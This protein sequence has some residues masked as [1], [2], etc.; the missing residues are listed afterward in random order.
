M[1]VCDISSRYSPHGNGYIK[2]YRKLL[3]SA[4]FQNEKLLKV[5]IWCLIR[6]NWHEATCIFEGKELK[7]ERG[8][9][10]TGRYSGSEECNMAPKT[11]Y[12][13]LLKLQEFGNLTLKSDNR[14]T[15][16][17]IINYSD[18]QDDSQQD[19]QQMDNSW[20]PDGHLMDTDKEVKNIRSKEYGVPVLEKWNRIAEKYNLSPVVKISKKR[21]AAILARL[22]EIEFNLDSIENEIALSDF[23]R[24]KNDRQWKIDFDFV[25]CSS[26]NYL[27]VLEGKYRNKGILKS[28][29]VSGLSLQM[30]K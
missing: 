20:T 16:V 11:F 23:L 28:E 30:N 7:L 22:R 5:W 25:F 10:L 1:K 6:A 8:T 17:S 29:P 13:Q 21:E 26:N 15:L 3:T 12:N 2:M 14:K 19:G 27:K 18:Y 24:G 9:F 4:V